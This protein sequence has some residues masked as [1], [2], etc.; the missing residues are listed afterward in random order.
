MEIE[1]ENGFRVLFDGGL[2]A[3]FTRFDLGVYSDK[4]CAPSDIARFLRIYADK[5]EIDKAV[6]ISYDET[7]MDH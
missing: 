3:H 5:L 7:D 4:P 1:D 2:N 6:E